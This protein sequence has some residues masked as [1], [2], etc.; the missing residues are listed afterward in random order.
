MIAT[1]PR[2]RAGLLAAVVLAAVV[3]LTGQ[4]RTPDHRAIGWAGE[5][6]L[7]VL[8]PVQVALDGALESAERWW[9]ALSEIGQ[10]RSENARLRAE[11]ERLHRR[12]AR[13]EEAQREVVRLR[14]LLQVRPLPPEV[15]RAARVVARDA[16]SWF[17]TLLVDRGARDGVRRHDAVVT[18]DGLVG[19]VLEVYPT[20]AR[21]LLLSDPRSAVGV[22]VQRTRDAAVVEGRAGP[23]LR[24]RY[25]S[26]DSEVRPGD[27]LVTSGL[28]GVFPR[29]IRVG[30]VRAILPKTGLFLEAE[31]TPAADLDRIE[32]VLVLLGSGREW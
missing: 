30:T 22:L 20:A 13:L 27:L 6:I 2:R 7:S 28:G 26:R 12:V 21:V 8:T 23:V 31:V 14:R 19:R 24:L 32:E 1:T 17:A 18:A 10:L 16:G 15:P 25:L 11:V 5:A 29:G 4:L 9:V 3:L